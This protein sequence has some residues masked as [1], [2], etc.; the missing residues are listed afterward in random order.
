PLSAPGRPVRFRLT[1]HRPAPSVAMKATKYAY[2]PSEISYDGATVSS[3]FRYAVKG[4]SGDA[5][6]S[7]RLRPGEGT[8]E[9]DR[10]YALLYDDGDGGGREKFD[11][12][13]PEWLHKENFL[14]AF[15][16]PELLATLDTDYRIEGQGDIDARRFLAVWDRK[17]GR[18]SPPLLGP[19]DLAHAS[20]REAT[21]EFFTDLCGRKV[22]CVVADGNRHSHQFGNT[23]SGVKN[24]EGDTRTLHI[25]NE[26]TVRRLSEAA[27]GADDVL[28]SARFRPNVVVNNLEPWAEFD[29]I[30]KTIEVVP[31]SREGDGGGTENEPPSLRLRVV[32]RTVR[33][34]GVGVDPLRPE[35]GTADIPD[36]LIK[37]F[38]E[39]GPYLGVYAV[40]DDP[41]CGGTMSVGDKLRVVGG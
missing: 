21:S 34:A 25:I 26:H 8:F 41:S 17:L 38:P 4:L 18:S 14:C 6:R 5:I 16:A 2:R 32:S 39:H 10:R 35:L 22:Q 13:D 11:G 7:A 36:L 15:T 20:G 37:H 28:S 23:S 1:C 27:F 24:N 9:D 3:L 31:A 30:G 33:C 19:V 40:V 29:L 12:E